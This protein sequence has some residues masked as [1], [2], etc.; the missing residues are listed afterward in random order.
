[1]KVSRPISGIVAIKLVA[2][3]TSIER[4]EKGSNHNLRSN[5]YYIV[6]IW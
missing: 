1:M 3:A 6:K 5:I 2:I 4:S